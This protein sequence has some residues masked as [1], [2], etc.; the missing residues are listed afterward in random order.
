VTASLAAAAKAV[1]RDGVP[2]LR[3]IAALDGLRLSSHGRAVRH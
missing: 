2:A 3:E 1:K